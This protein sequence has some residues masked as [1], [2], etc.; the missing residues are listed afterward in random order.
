MKKIILLMLSLVL[1]CSSMLSLSRISKIDIDQCELKETWENYNSTGM[2]LQYYECDGSNI[3]TLTRRAPMWSKSNN[4]IG[5][6][7][8]QKYP[9]FLL[10]GYS[11]EADTAKI[12]WKLNEESNSMEEAEIYYKAQSNEE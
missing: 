6:I 7:N 12:T 8:Y 10:D 11:W 4:M 5:G 3:A 2:L 9:L 1:G